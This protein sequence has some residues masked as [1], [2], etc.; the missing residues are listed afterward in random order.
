[1][2]HLEQHHLEQYYFGFV[3]FW[4]AGIPKTARFH[5]HTYPKFVS[6]VR[7]P[8]PQCH[9]LFFGTSVSLGDLYATRCAHSFFLGSWHPQSGSFA[10]SSISSTKLRSILIPPR[11][12]F[13]PPRHLWS[14]SQRPPLTYLGFG[15]LGFTHRNLVFNSGLSRFILELKLEFAPD[16]PERG[17][18]LVCPLWVYW[19]HV[20]NPY[21]PF[22]LPRGPKFCHAGRFKNLGGDWIAQL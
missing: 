3:L 15:Y 16:C 11:E 21:F 18:F 13:G 8:S 12:S 2:C 17:F 19:K 14:L 4:L 7:I 20:F 9:R 6:K 5:N 22:E 10:K 1:M